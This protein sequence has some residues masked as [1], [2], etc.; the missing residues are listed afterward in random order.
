[1]DVLRTP[2][3]RFADLPDFDHEPRRVEVEGGLR[4]AYVEAGPAGGRPVILLHGEPTWSFLYR[5]LLPVLAAAGLRAIAPDMIGFGRSDKPTDIA[6]HSYA[7]HVSWMRSALFDALDLRHVILVGQDWGGLIGLRLVADQPERFAGVVA[8]NTGLPTGLTRMP[9]VW[10]RFRDVVA[11][12]PAL[13]IAR[14]VASGCLRRPDDRVLAA[15]DAPF[16]G[17]EYK[18]GV[19]AMPRLV[20][21][22]PDDPGGI[23][24][25][26]AW[27]RLAH[28][29]APFLCAF[30]DSDPIT[31][32]A[33]KP[34][35]ERI[36]GAQGQAHVTI[37]GAGHFV[38]EDA[39]EELGR[40]VAG[41]AGSLSLH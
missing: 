14:L 31:A 3:E 1:M 29:R 33:D 20:P 2:E 6:A 4:M 22:A 37:T 17:E 15:Y 26:A 11:S 19:R 25:R 16:P 10:E 40:V 7:A 12:A 38:Q 39:G 24:N 13:D 27:R 21:N 36:P 18:V 23:A 35:R 5:K 30:S 34:M 8:S 9:A 41:F 32:G 28:V